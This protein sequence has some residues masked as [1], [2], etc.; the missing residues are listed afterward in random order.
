MSEPFWQGKIKLKNSN[1]KLMISFFFQDCLMVLALM[2]S[3]N[4]MVKQSSVVLQEYMEICK[5]K[6]KKNQTN[7]KFISI[8]SES[9]LT[10]VNF[11]LKF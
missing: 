5:I 7:S 11:N 10:M 4:T 2:N 3:K 8:V 6:K 9:S 1:Y